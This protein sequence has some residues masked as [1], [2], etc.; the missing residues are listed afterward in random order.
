MTVLTHH[1][2]FETSYVKGTTSIQA[3]PK[4]TILPSLIFYFQSLANR[5]SSRL[6]GF[7]SLHKKET[8]DG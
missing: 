5:Q 8:S 7:G 4:Q 3:G 1:A 2:V 6:K